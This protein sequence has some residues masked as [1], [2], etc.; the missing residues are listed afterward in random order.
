VVIRKGD[1]NGDG[2]GALGVGAGG[3]GSGHPPESGSGAR[4]EGLM[5]VGA[6]GGSRGSETPG[7][8]GIQWRASQMPPASSALLLPARLYQKAAVTILSAFLKLFILKLSWTIPTRH[9]DA[10]RSHSAAPQA[11]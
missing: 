2:C 10:S 11:K 9:Y 3:A 6:P 8:A 5:L 1:G 7:F 4:Q